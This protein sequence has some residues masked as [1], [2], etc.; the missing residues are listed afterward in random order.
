LEALVSGLGSILNA[1]SVA[2]HGKPL[3]KTQKEKRIRNMQAFPMGFRPTL[4][5][6]QKIARYIEACEVHEIPIPTYKDAV[7]AV[8]A[9][10]V[11]DPSCWE[12]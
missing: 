4:A 9:L 10:G 7:C 3:S 12:G 11:A 2:L 8:V 5:F 6:S 1:N